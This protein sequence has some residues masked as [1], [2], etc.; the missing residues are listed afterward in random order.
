MGAVTRDCL[1][2]RN[3][4]V[5]EYIHVGGVYLVG[6][7]ISIDSPIQIFRPHLL[8]QYLNEMDKKLA[9]VRVRHCH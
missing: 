2:D 8:P 7:T 5:L 3:G 9:P 4:T 6:H 1:I